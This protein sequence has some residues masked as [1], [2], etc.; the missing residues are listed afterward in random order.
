MPLLIDNQLREIGLSGPEIVAFK[1]LLDAAVAHRRAHWNKLDPADQE[2]WALDYA[3]LVHECGI[4]RVYAGMRKAW[5]WNKFLA[6]AAEVRECLPP[7]PDVP[8]PRAIHNP[9]CVDCGGSGWKYMPANQWGNRRVAK[10][11]CNTRPHKMA[12]RADPVAAAEIAASVA[13]L[14]KE[15]ETSRPRTY[16]YPRPAPAPASI[17]PTTA[18]LAAQLG[19][20]P[21]TAEQTAQ[22]KPMDRAEC[23]RVEEQLVEAERA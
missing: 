13:R 3:E 11:D 20:A 8:K 23:Q 6:S 2:C 1:K 14:N 16:K 4:S 21:V 12:P 9:S 15:M 10:C 22:R 18:E 17:I 19:L 7:L 5:T